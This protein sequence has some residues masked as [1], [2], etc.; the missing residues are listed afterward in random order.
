[1]TF[2]NADYNNLFRY[3]IALSGNEDDALDLLHQALEHYYA[4]CKSVTSDRA[5]ENPAAYIRQSMKNLFIDKTRHQ[6]NFM[7]EN[8]EASVNEPVLIDS[9]NSLEDILISKQEFSFCWESMNVDERDLMFSIAIEGYTAKEI[10]TQ[11]GLSRGTILSRIHR[12][13]SRLKKHLMDRNRPEKAVK[14]G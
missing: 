10:A 2:S 5:P 8:F 3:G 13:K 1:M 14:N 11:Q 12:I 4:K 7:H 9:E 6:K